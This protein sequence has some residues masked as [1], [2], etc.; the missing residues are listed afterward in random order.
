MGSQACSLLL[1]LS[2]DLQRRSSP[3]QP[4]VVKWHRSWQRSRRLTVVTTPKSTRMK[5][6][7]TMRA[8]VV[9]TAVGAE[10]DQVNRVRRLPER[11]P[12]H[13]P[14]SLPGPT[15]RRLNLPSARRR[16]RLPNR[17]HGR[18]R[19]PQRPPSLPKDGRCSSVAIRYAAQTQAGLG[20]H[21]RQ[22]KHKT[23]VHE[24]SM[25]TRLAWY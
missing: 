12:G 24:R 13:P 9:A 1:H 19:R 5:Q 17:R 8:L 21:V 15:K 4:T 23:Y 7:V 2:I 25:L 18:L 6:P 16:R 14:H 20:L 22:K 3:G 11:N 10:V